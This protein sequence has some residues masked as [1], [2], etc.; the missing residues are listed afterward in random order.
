M[1]LS[2]ACKDDVF[3]VINTELKILLSASAFP[4]YGCVNVLL[5][6]YLKR[7]YSRDSI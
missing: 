5:S 4:A 1:L 7:F 6:C 3:S 2:G